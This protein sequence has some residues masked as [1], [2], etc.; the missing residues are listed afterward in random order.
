[1]TAPSPAP[2]PRIL[3]PFLVL[4]YPQTIELLKHYDNRHTDLVKFAAGLSAAVPSVVFAFHELSPAPMGSVW[5]FAGFLGSVTG[6]SL[7][8]LLAALVQN[9]LY[10]VFPARQANAI[11]SALFVGLATPTN[12]MYKSTAF[13]AF[14]SSSSQIIQLLFVALQAGLFF[15]IATYAFTG[16]DNTSIG[17]AIFVGVAVTLVAFA[18]A[19]LYLSGKGGK[20]ADEAVHGIRVA[21]G[22]SDKFAKLKNEIEEFVVQAGLKGK[23]VGDN[24]LREV[25]ESEKK[26]TAL[27]KQH[28]PPP[29]RPW[30]RV[31]R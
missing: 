31:W 3:D 27:V 28:Q 17:V 6:L 30:W 20:T 5:V 19:A 25:S 2:G 14:K 13:S 21:S 29:P 4:E 22:I 7:L 16:H 26:L 8:A 12:H 9:R 23:P 15:G 24:L 18:V 1:M 11:R 10:F